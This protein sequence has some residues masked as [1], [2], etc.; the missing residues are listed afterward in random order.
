MRHLVLMHI[1]QGTSDII[2]NVQYQFLGHVHLPMTLK[3]IKSISLLIKINYPLLQFYKIKNPKES[4]F[5][6]N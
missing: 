2:E 1:F 3:N 5:Y 4:S 6:F